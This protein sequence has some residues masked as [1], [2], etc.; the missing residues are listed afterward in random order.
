MNH[1]K[2][3]TSEELSNHHDLNWR[4]NFWNLIVYQV[5]LRIGWIFKTESVVMPACLDWLGGAGWV[6]G[7]LPIFNRFGQSIPPLLASRWLA[8]QPLKKWVVAKTTLLMSASFLTLAFIFGAVAYRYPPGQLPTWLPFLFI[9]VYAVFFSCFGINQLAQNTLQGK[10]IPVQKRGSL[11]MW[12]SIIGVVAAV[13]SAVVLLPMWLSP[14]K[15]AFHY[16]FGVTGAMFL[17]ASFAASL[18]SEEADQPVDKEKAP[19][20]LINSA[21]SVLVFDH[22][23]RWLAIV[24]AAFGLNMVL[25]PHYHALA[26]RELSA[27]LNWLMPWLVAQ[28]IGA[29][30]FSTIAGKLADRLGNRIALQFTL[31][32]QLLAP[33]VAVAV[34]LGGPTQLPLY[35]AVFVM[36]GVTPVV[37]RLF[38]NITLEYVQRRH[39]PKY[40]STLAICLALPPMLLS[41]P[42]GYL[43]DIFGFRP[44]FLGVSLILLLGL[45][46][47][48]KIREPRHR[49]KV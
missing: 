23:F 19:A 34:S 29:A 37:Y 38:S 16:I 33:L 10:I 46:G 41:I 44:I 48:L 43:I 36:L 8:R 25:F 24:A 28:N 39:H 32:F 30:M 27:S 35:L 49:K 31:A 3:D 15:A 45:I 7:F 13:S 11:M 22:Q 47:T 18:V 17:I 9:A 21:V 42:V 14:Q 40:L 4:K 20:S 12:S 26:S 1:N 6:R 5:L 2:Q